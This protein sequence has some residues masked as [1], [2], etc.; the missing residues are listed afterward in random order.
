MRKLSARQKRILKRKFLIYTAIVAFVLSL[1][2]LRWLTFLPEINIVNIKVSGPIKEQV[3][4][5][6]FA[7]DFLD[8]RSDFW[9][10]GHN[11]LLFPKSRL[12]D[13][14]KFNFPEL[15]KAEISIKKLDSLDI[16]ISYRYGEFLLCAENGKLYLTDSSGYVFKSAEGRNVNKKMQICAPVEFEEGQVVLNQLPIRANIPYEYIQLAKRVKFFFA[17]KKEFDVKKME[18]KKDENRIYINDFYLKTLGQKDLSAQLQNFIFVY[19]QKGSAWLNSLEYADL[20][21]DGKVYYKEKTQEQETEQQ[22][23]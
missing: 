16:D 12:S 8:A 22:T 23:H 19:K 17:D 1:V 9:F 4:I 7:K 6:N 14:I 15:E 18:I 3:K 21:F 11:A 5:R 2:F 10:S 13:A 20:R